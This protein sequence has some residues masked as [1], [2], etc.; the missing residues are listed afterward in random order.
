MMMTSTARSEAPIGVLPALSGICSRCSGDD[1]HWFTPT[2]QPR[3][4]GVFLCRTCGAL[5]VVLPRSARTLAA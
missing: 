3:E 4:G 5:N 2:D 1:V